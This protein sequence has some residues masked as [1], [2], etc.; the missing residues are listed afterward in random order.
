VNARYA[1]ATTEN[2]DLGPGPTPSL[3]ATL[4]TRDFFGGATF[5]SR[6]S[7]DLSHEL[8]LG[9]ESSVRTYGATT[10]AATAFADV[11]A[12]VGSDPALP[13][14]FQRT[15]VR[16]SEGLQYQVGPHR[17]KFGGGLAFN[18][19]DQTYAFGSGGTFFFSGLATSPSASG[20]SC[21]A[22]RCRPQ[23]SSQSE[24]TVCSSRI[25]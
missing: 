22:C 7:Q 15:V 21:R 11:G 24:S 17:V 8:R 25:S 13:G 4:D 20:C 12:P 19:Y 6:L 9:V 14:R 1:T 3:G 16:A 5:G 18:S 2:P 10:P 23:L